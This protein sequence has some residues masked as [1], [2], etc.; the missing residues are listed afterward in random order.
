MIAEILKVSPLTGKEATKQ[1]VLESISAVELVHIAAHPGWAKSRMGRR[2]RS[3]IKI[4]E[5]DS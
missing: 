5:K 4:K 3:K 1:K 2:S